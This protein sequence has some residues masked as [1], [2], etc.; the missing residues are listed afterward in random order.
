VPV[1]CEE[2]SSWVRAAR[3]AVFFTGAGIST[4][5]GIPDF[6][7][8]TGLWTRYD[9]REMTFQKFV[10][11]ADVR[12]LSWQMR[13]ELF[14]R[15]YEPN[16]GHRAIARL[17]ELG[18]VRGVVTQN[19]DR[20]HQAAGSRSVLELHGH[21]TET[22][23]LSCDWTAPTTE[24]LSWEEDDPRCRDCGG[25]LK[26]RTISFGQA[27]PAEAVAEAARWSREADLFFAVGSSL[28]VYP[29]AALP[30]EAVHAG[31]RLVI[32]ND[33]PTPYDDVAHAVLRGKAGRILPE[34]VAGL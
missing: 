3:S 20:L 21:V 10:A 22:G 4:E 30:A 5:S 24:V 15:T 32:V 8:P 19:I 16:E 6:R 28:V 33:E 1:L 12:K 7:S 29:A 9:P 18:H 11:S 23:C 31:A 34:V 14:S 13:R 25:I 27:M 2:V 26:P 17:E